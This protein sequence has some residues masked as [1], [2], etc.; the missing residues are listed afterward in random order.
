MERIHGALIVFA[1]MK[2]ALMRAEKRAKRAFYLV[3]DDTPIE[4]ELARE[5]L[6]AVEDKMKLLDHLLNSKNGDDS[7]PPQE[8]ERTDTS[9]R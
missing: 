8:N 5:V 1:T 3:H 6:R 4:V 2:A 7:C 9:S